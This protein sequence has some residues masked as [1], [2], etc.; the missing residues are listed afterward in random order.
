M[1]EYSAQ[2]GKGSAGGG[3]VGNLFLLPFAL[4]IWNTVQEIP[5]G[6][7]GAV[8]TPE[9][10][11]GI[12]ALHWL[13]VFLI[14]IFSINGAA[15]LGLI[16]NVLVALVGCGGLIFQIVWIIMGISQQLDENNL[17]GTVDKPE[18]IEMNTVMKMIC[19]Y[20][21]LPVFACCGLLC[22]FGICA[23]VMRR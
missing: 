7:D 4:Y 8:Q 3:L 1:D 19:I 16:H 21:M 6:A 13:T 9:E 2:A 17:C 20:S 22:V 10:Y 18:M 14:A 23:A 11:C 5:K 12:D 15:L